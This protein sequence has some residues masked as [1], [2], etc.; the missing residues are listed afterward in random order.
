MRF[1][2]VLAGVLA[3]AFA[4]SAVRAQGSWEVVHGWPILPE[5]V[6]LGAVAGVGVDSRGDVFVFHRAERPWPASDVLET[7]PIAGATVAIFDGRSGA[8]V[9]QWGANRFAMPHGLTVDRQDNV[10][11]TDVALH[12]VYKFSRDGK[13]LLTLGER[14][15]PGNDA[16]HFNLPT[17]VAAAPDGSFYVSDGYVNTRVVKF[18][19]DGKFLFQW[20]TKGSGPGQFDL[21]HGIALD[22]AGRVYVADRS[23][24]RVQ[25][26]D[27]NGRFIAE[28]KGA[29]LGRPYDVA[30]AGDGTAFVAD[31]GDQPKAPPDRSAL[32]IVRP[33]GSVAERVGRYGNYDGQFA[34]AHDIAVGKDDSVYVGDILGA[35][36]QK[37]VHRASAAGTEKEI[38]ELVGLY[39]SAWQAKDAPA[40][41]RLLAPEYGYFTSTGGYSDRAATLAFLA[42]PGY[43]LTKSRRSDLEATVDG[44]V[45]RVRS[46]WEGEGRYRGEPVKDDQTCGQTWIRSEAGWRLFTEHCANRTRP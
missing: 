24:A 10:F 32:V 19:A 16:A 39:D 18:S 38:R 45:A 30:V 43:A 42:D 21:P 7:T 20:G 46:R 14:A 2:T 33:D 13:L 36:I 22:A 41:E 35:R 1:R 31:G 25:V 29:A 34:L 26:F 3:L 12:Q 9:S 6:M 17:D 23:N 15:V 44:P 8:L 11:L 28:W 4:G 37:F 40:V 27:G 5:G